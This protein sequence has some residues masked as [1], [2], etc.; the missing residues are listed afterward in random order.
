[1]NTNK[2][3][4]DTSWTKM[5]INLANKFLK[6]TEKEQTTLL[7]IMEM[8]SG[9]QDRRDLAESWTGKIEDLPAALARIGQKEEV[10]C[11]EFLDMCAAEGMTADEYIKAHNLA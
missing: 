3:I 9:N 7:I 1:M 10:T 6:L 5:E 8:I 11:S 4:F 2:S